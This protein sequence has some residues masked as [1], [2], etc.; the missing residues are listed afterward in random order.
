MGYGLSLFNRYEHWIRSNESRAHS[1]VGAT[2]A[3]YAI[4]RELFRELP[5][6]LILDDM[7]TPLQIVM[8]GYRCVLE[9]SALAVDS[10]DNRSEF[11]RK[12]RTLTGNYQL[13]TLLPGLLLP[14]NPIFLQ[15]WCHK[16]SRLLVPFF[17][18]SLFGAS[19]A[20]GGGWYQL[21]LAAQVLFYLTALSSR[22]LQ[23][24]PGLAPV[25]NAG[26]AF[27]MANCAA[28]LC[29]IFFLRRKKDLWV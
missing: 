26:Y 9:E 1:M 11:R 3:L 5:E 13:L 19:L 15:Y 24:F 17:L 22:H 27:V 12:L 29:V 2:G 14:S 21:A 6:E 8:R 10:R 18:L 25:A 20:L 4:R 28:F 23:R 16:L 7:Y